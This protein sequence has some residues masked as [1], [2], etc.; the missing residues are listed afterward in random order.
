MVALAGDDVSGMA[1]LQLAYFLLN[2]FCRNQA[3][4]LSAC[5]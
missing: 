2:M 4:G 5:I 1:R 3:T